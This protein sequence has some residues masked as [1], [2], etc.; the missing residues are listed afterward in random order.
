M[1]KIDIINGVV[2]VYDNEFKLE[3]SVELSSL[4]Q[5]TFRFLNGDYKLVSINLTQPIKRVVKFSELNGLETTAAFE[6]FIYDEMSDEEKSEFDNFI[7][8][9]N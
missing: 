3:K 9:L 4:G 2:Y 5:F 6:E 7:T 1:E 8:L